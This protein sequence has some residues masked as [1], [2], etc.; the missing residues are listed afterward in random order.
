MSA[1]S[2]RSVN[3]GTDSEPGATRMELTSHLALLNFV[4]LLLS[5]VEQK[6]VRAFIWLDLQEK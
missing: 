6:T 4:L 2:A 1:G 3:M 5:A